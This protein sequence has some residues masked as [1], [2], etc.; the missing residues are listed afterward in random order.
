MSWSLTSCQWQGGHSYSF[1]HKIYNSSAISG[2]QWFLFCVINYFSNSPPNSAA[3][4]SSQLTVGPA[5]WHRPNLEAVAIEPQWWDVDVVNIVTWWIL[6]L[7]ANSYR[8]KVHLPEIYS[9]LFFFLI[10]NI[11]LPGSLYLY[12]LERCPKYSKDPVALH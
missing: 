8:I 7:E 5:G 2:E 12:R 6:W 3:N 10:K 4:H 1:I 11:R 9:P